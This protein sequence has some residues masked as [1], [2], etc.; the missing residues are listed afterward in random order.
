MQQCISFWPTNCYQDLFP[1]LFVFI[2]HR[3]RLL[4]FVLNQLF[5]RTKSTAD[6][7]EGNE[8]INWGIFRSTI[9]SSQFK[10]N[11][12]LKRWVWTA[13]ECVPISF[14]LTAQNCQIHSRCIIVHI[15]FTQCMLVNKHKCDRKGTKTA[16][17]DEISHNSHE[18][19]FLKMFSQLFEIKCSTN[20]K[21][22]ELI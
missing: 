9:S 15:A 22:N 13:M 8:I 12:Q 4:E 11:E 17:K 18:L 2:F 21:S 5:I 7:W 1:S 20:K 14:F 6:W 16:T 19:D 10:F 3:R